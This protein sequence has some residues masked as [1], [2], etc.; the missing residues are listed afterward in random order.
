MR[1][2]HSPEG[3]L[4]VSIGQT[5]PARE[6]KT[7]YVE[8]AETAAA[9]TATA[10]TATAET[11]TVA[12]AS[13]SL[14]ASLASGV[15]A[16]KVSR[17]SRVPHTPPPRVP[18]VYLIEKVPLET[19]VVVGCLVRQFFFTLYAWERRTHT[20]KHFLSS[21]AAS[22]LKLRSLQAEEE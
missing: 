17:Q 20:N 4:V 1:R 14:A 8:T 12:A 5:R 7:K 16:T 18:T 6:K 3:Q 2:E 22:L 10:E 9:E 11:A 21:A 19:L 13:Q 15:A